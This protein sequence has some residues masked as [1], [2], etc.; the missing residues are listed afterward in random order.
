M[1]NLLQLQKI[2]DL[3]VELFGDKKTA[4]EWLNTPN[5]LFFDKTPLEYAHSVNAQSVIDTLLEMML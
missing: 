1:N 5:H 4:N 3:A 2:Y